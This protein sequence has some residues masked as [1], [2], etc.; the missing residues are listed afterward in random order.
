M[1][2]KAARQFERDYKATLKEKP[3]MMDLTAVRADI[4][5]RIGNQ[6]RTQQAEAIRKWQAKVTS[7]LSCACK[8]LRGSG[9]RLEGEPD[10]RI[11]N[12][13]AKCVDKFLWP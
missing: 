6:R 3:D 11:E 5:R 9:P 1:I 13:Y 10:E 4:M 2:Q 7:S 12:S 8:W